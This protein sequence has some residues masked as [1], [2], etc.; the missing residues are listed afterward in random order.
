VLPVGLTH[1]REWRILV[2]SKTLKLGCS[3]AFLRYSESL[4][5]L[6]VQVPGA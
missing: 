2:W 5:V 1:R 6:G 4:R 3:A